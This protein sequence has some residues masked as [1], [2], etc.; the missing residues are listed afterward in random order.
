[1]AWVYLL[2]A[3][4]MEVGW[5]VGLKYAAGEDGKIHFWP[6]A[7]A[8][9]SITNRTTDRAQKLAGEVG[10]RVVDWGNRHT[11]MCD[12]LVNCTS[13]GMHPNVD[14]SPVHFSILKPGV[15]VFDTIYN[16][17]TTM[18][19]RE[20]RTRGCDTITGVD[21]FVRQAARQVELFTGLRPD[22]D[23]MRQIVRKALSP[24]TKVHDDAEDVEKGEEKKQ[25]E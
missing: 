9:V 4:C 15:T 17:E 20:A 23:V 13:V 5:P 16:P 19:I 22:L 24:L 18:L 10:A 12:I 21:M 2:I 11:G 25:G 1:M 8:A 14:E 6:A 7:G 3:G